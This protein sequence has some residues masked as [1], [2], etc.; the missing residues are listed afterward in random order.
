MIAY[1]TSCQG[2]LR[3]SARVEPEQEGCKVARAFETQLGLLPGV[4]AREYGAA[5]GTM[6]QATPGWIWR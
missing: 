5:K 1:V 2:R 6:T 3:F 4:E